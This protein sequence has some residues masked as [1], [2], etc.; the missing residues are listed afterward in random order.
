MLPL[1][2]PAAGLLQGAGAAAAAAASLR[3]LARGPISTAQ[4]LLQQRAAPPPP[5]CGHA[6]AQAHHTAAGQDPAVKEAEAKA[7]SKLKQHLRVSRAPSLPRGYGR[8]RP[9][10]ESPRTTTLSSL[11]PTTTPRHTPRHA[12]H[13]P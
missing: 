2:Q 5:A 11:F 12:T 7:P 10:D 8:L 9:A 1:L 4:L 6:Q 3:L 13:P